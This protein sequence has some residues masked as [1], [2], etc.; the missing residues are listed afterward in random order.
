MQKVPNPGFRVSS[1]PV[2][3]GDDW[4]GYFYRGDELPTELLSYLRDYYAPDQ[5][6]K[7]RITREIDRLN[8]CKE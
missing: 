8:E 4:C 5:A 2:K 6:L 1:G 7:G 3:F